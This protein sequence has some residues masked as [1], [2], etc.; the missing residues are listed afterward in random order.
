MWQFN[1]KCTV[2]IKRVPR[3]PWQVK[4]IKSFVSSLEFHANEFFKQPVLGNESAINSS[5]RLNKYEITKQCFKAI[6]QDRISL[7]VK[8]EILRFIREQQD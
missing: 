8:L 1:S 4:C 2:K 5:M 7:P 3:K 6:K